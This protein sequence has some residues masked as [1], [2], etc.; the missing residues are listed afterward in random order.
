MLLAEQGVRVRVYEASPTL[1][2][3]PRTLIATSRLPDVLGFTPSEAVVNQVTHFELTSRSHSARVN[4]GEPDLIVERRTLVRVLAKRAERAGAELMLGRRLVSISSSNRSERGPIAL[5]FSGE[6]GV[7]GLEEQADY[8]IGADGVHSAVA[9]S[10]SRLEV[11]EVFLTQAIV[12]LPPGS[13][14][15][16]VRVWFDRST[17][18][19]FYWLIPV[20][21]SKG[22]VGLIADNARQAER[23]LHS[24]L[25]QLNLDPLELQVGSVATHG[26][27][28]RPWAAVGGCRLL[29]VGDAAGQVKMT[30][31]GGLVTGLRG[32]RAAAEAIVDR[33]DYRRQLHGLKRELD[34]HLVI[35]AI[36]DRFSDADYDA[37]LRGLNPAV[38]S[39]L[40]GH[41]RDEMA[42]AFWYLPF[43]QP[44]LPY[45]AI[46]A[47]LGRRRSQL[48]TTR[49]DR[50]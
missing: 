14:A 15:R 4:L 30:T 25:G 22:A 21:R 47:L 23:A 38:H 39:I 32:A 5:R 26:Y 12:H 6:E 19:F 35:R 7:A 45:L 37:L 27:S 2:G 33:V 31:V 16:C 9:L 49:H 50:G 46:R 3:V 44:K 11:E 10:G 24:F 34:V 17:T 18:R 48:S 43:A 20:A 42:R 29:L 28:A 1:N 40:E 36:L 41:T 8:V 13:D